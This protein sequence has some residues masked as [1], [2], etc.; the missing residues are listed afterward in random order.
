MSTMEGAE[1]LFLNEIDNYTKQP[2]NHNNLIRITGAVTSFPPGNTVGLSHLSASIVVDLEYVAVGEMAIGSLWQFIC[3]LC[4]FDNSSGH[5]IVFKAL[6]ARNVT[7]LD[8]T[9]Y[10]AA[11]RMRRK[12]L[13]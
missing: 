4:H 11:V 7:G 13:A 9:L 5:H 6:V 10:E 1:V 3:R 8:M 2:S 12:F